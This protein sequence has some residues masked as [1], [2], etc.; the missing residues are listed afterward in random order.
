VTTSPTQNLPAVSSSTLSNP[1]KFDTIIRYVYCIKLELYAIY[2]NATT[3][4]CN[5]NSGDVDTGEVDDR[6]EEMNQ[7]EADHD[8]ADEVSEEV[9]SNENQVLCEFKLI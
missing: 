2:W 8:V 3:N 4:S 9:D 1:V 7:E 6:G 5:D